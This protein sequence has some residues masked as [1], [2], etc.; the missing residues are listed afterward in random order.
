MLEAPLPYKVDGKAFEGLLVRPEASETPK[1]AVAVCHAWGGRDSFAEGIAR[2]LAAE[3]YLACAL[4]VRA[5]DGSDRVASL[6]HD[7]LEAL[8][9]ILYL[10]GDMTEPDSIGDHGMSSLEPIG[11]L[12]DL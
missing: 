2:R 9:H 7:A 10:E 11:V 6:R 4:D 12:E 1:A 5:N 3:G 8:S